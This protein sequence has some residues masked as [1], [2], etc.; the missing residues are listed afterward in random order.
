[1]LKIVR[2][3]ERLIHGQVVTS[4]VTNESIT[5]IMVVDKSVCND[6]LRK[7]LM[8]MAVPE[9]I[10]ILFVD[11]DEAVR[12]YEEECEYEDLMMIFG[13]PYD[14]LEFINKGGKLN[15]VNVGGMSCKGQRRQVCTSVFADEKEMEIFRE[16]AGKNVVLEAKMLPTDKSVDL[17]K[18]I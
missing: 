13:N 18:I 11:V 1:M 7:S 4:W 6:E 17:T 5:E 12:T 10:S 14:I 9:Y 15:R 16:I 2:L 3:D 8:S